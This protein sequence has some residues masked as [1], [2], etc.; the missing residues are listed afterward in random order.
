[1]PSDVLPDFPFRESHHDRLGERR[2]DAEFLA[3]AWVDPSS[4]VLVMNG[5]DL[6]VVTKDGIPTGLH[7]V[8]PDTA[9]AG[10]RMLLGGVDGRV[11]FLV[12]ADQEAV[13]ARDA[14]GAGGPTDALTEES[15]Y[16]A[17][18]EI[19]LRVNDVEAGLAV[20]AAALA[21][22][23]LRHPRCSVCGAAT[24]VAMAGESR[25]CPSCGAAHFPRTDPA[26]IMLVEDAAGRCLLGHNL[27]RR[28]TWYSTLAGFVEPGETPEQAVVREVREETSVEVSDVRYA[29]SQPW[30]FPSSLMLGFFARA[31][32]TDVVVDGEEIGAAGWFTRDDVRRQVGSG[33]L[34]LPTTISIA[35]ALISAWYGGELPPNRTD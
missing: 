32:T 11:H 28:T 25:S 21:N 30:P 6:A 31:T 22:W 19:A 26:V 27:A 20:H 24:E 35:G 12:L 5:P 33:E 17:L 3:R 34:V 9:P 16:A 29:G 7:W 1:V 4:R 14:P 2:T 8:S 23:H 10:E 18:R 13:D 15:G